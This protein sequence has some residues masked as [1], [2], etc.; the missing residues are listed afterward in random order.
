MF[1]CTGCGAC[2]R[3]IG[4][5]LE[6]I[7]DMDFPEGSVGNLL[8]IFPYPFD[9][10]GACS[11]LDG[12]LCKVYEDRPLVCRI[13]DLGAA[14]GMNMQDFYSNN[15]TRCNELMDEEGLDKSFRIE[16]PPKEE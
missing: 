1:P 5:V 12:N 11:Q 16:W 7:M 14:L 10:K 6:P 8:K 13:D 3:K 9:E 15:I 2:C 4:S